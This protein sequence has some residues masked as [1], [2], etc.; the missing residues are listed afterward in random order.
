MVANGSSSDNQVFAQSI[1]PPH[2][3]SGYGQPMISRLGLLVLTWAI[4][5]SRGATPDIPFF[6]DRSE[7]FRA[8]GELAGATM[9]KVHVNKDG[10]VYVLTDRGM[11]RLFGDKLALDR[12][13]R[14]LNGRKIL[15]SALARGEV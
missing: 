4:I 6:Q 11:A 13:F 5:V 2:T 10:I 3:A 7:Q 14:P 12:S 9:K 15:D 8:E 1:L